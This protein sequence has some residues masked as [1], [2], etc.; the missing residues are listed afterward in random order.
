VVKEWPAQEQTTT[1]PTTTTTTTTPHESL[2]ADDGGD[3]DVVFP[4]VAP[5]KR[6]TKKPLREQNSFLYVSLR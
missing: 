4:A 3:D 1:T 2:E 6:S 5:H